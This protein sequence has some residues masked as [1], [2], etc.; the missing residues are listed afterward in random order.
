MQQNWI[1]HYQVHAHSNC[2]FTNS[3]LLLFHLF[4]HRC[5]QWCFCSTSL[6]VVSFSVNLQEFSIFEWHTT[7]RYFTDYIF[8]WK[9]D[10]SHFKI[11]SSYWQKST[12]STFSQPSGLF[13]IWTP[14][15]YLMAVSIE[16]FSSI[17]PFQYFGC[18]TFLAF[19]AFMFATA[20]V[21]TMKIQLR[22]I[23]K[24]ASRGKYR[25]NMYETLCKFIRTHAHLKQLGGWLICG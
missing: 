14:T 13:I 1:N 11:D 17:Y 8:S 21:K 7:H 5:E 15:G 4:H 10:F 9:K 25:K 16:I 19:G 18:F 3:Y 2:H 12:R 24:E 6:N 20:F 23:N 22:S